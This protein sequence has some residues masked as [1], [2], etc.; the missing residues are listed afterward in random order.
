[1]KLTKEQLIAGAYSIAPSWNAYCN[2]TIKEIISPC[3]TGGWRVKYEAGEELSLKDGDVVIRAL[4]LAAFEEEEENT[5][6]V[7]K[8][9]DCGKS[10][11][12]N[13]DLLILTVHSSHDIDVCI[14][15]F[16]DSRKSANRRKQ[17]NEQSNACASCIHRYKSKTNSDNLCIR[18]EVQIPMETNICARCYMDGQGKLR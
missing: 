14:P 3:S 12:E 13:T 15:C 16:M 2:D 4:I 10:E 8:C 5:R 9:A 18:C 1:M 7:R 17:V 11:V 6:E